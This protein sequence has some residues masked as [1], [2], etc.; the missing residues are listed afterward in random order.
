MCACVELR[1][2]TLN[3]CKHICMY[4]CM[5]VCMYIEPFII[6]CVHVRICISPAVFMYIIA[7]LSS[8]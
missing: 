4:V 2:T 7:V 5:Y 1:L 3:A 6:L 8:I